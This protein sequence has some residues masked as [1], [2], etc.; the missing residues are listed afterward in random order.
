[1]EF[2]TEKLS[3]QL[4]TLFIDQT[5]AQCGSVQIW[6]R[7]GSALEKKGDEGIAHFLEHMFFKGTEKRPGAQ[8]ARDV[9]TFG[10]EINAFT[11]FDYTC[12]YINFP[13]SKVKESLHT[14]LDM[15]SHPQFLQKELLPERGVVFE[16]YRRSQDNPNH[17]HFHALQDHCFSHGYAHP[18]LGFEETIKKFSRKQLLRFRSCHYNVNNALLVVAGNLQQREQLK[19]I[20]TTYQLPQGPTS[21]FPSFNLQGKTQ[22]NIHKK[23]VR[24]IQTTLAIQAPCYEDKQGAQEDLAINALGYGESSPLY[25]GLVTQNSLAN[26][27]SGST[28]FLAKGGVHL[29]RLVCPPTHLEKVYCEVIKIFKT[30]LENGISD[31]DIEKIKNQYIASKIYEKES[32]ESFSFSLGHGFAQNGD[33]HCEHKFIESL[34]KCT[35]TEVHQALMTI[36]KKPIY[37]NIQ[38]PRETQIVGV[39]KIAQ[40]LQQNLKKLSQVRPSKRRPHLPLK[41]SAF[42]PQ[43]SGLALKEGIHLI[44]RYGPMTPTFNMYAF[45]KGGLCEENKKN[46]GLYNIMGH[47]LAKGYKGKNDRDLKLE[48]DIMSSS[49]N[50]ISGKSSYG[51]GLHGLSEYSENLFEIFLKSLTSPLFS[52]KNLAHEKKMVQRELLAQQEEPAKQCFR[53]V[54]EIL[55]SGHPYALPSLGSPESVRKIQR[56]TIIDTHRKNLRGKEIVISFSG[57]LELEKVLDMIGPYLK[58]LP[59]RKKKKRRAKKLSPIK[60]FSHHQD[61]VREQTQ[62]FIGTRTF[63]YGHKNDIFIKMLTAH[64]A[65]QSSELFVNVRDKKG[66]CYVV[67]PTH[68]CAEEAGHWG[69]YMASGTDKTQPAIAAINE[70]LNRY[71]KQGLN[72]A[73]FDRVKSMISGQNLLNIQTNDDYAQIYSIPLL[74]GLPLDHHHQVIQSIQNCTHEKFNQVIKSVLSKKRVQITVGMP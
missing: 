57:N 54:N 55:F 21:Q 68:F 45:I 31:E 43:V 40:Q 3:N 73:E 32:L 39:K 27:A 65:G 38:V 11:S 67:Q 20:I 51:L 30:S 48:L 17:Y 44:H 18:I 37:I 46:N 24:M 23:D 63:P 25:K 49:L 66:L 50:G 29:I 42:D 6:F 34:K 13:H 14:L 7:A 28:M 61:L 72:K 69:I 74:Q 22:I 59:S 4:Q 33:I 36:F 35:A 1:M 60:S 8:I 71:Q 47:L 64:L 9:E 2:Q 52:A 26:M 53:M 58:Q 10:G 70:I 12:Y 15:V 56:Q 62:I 19:K 16:E 41:K 5:G